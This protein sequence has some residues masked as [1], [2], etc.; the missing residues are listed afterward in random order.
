MANFRIAK[1]NIHRD[2]L[3]LEEET[4]RRYKNPALTIIN[5]SARQIAMYGGLLGLDPCS[6]QKIQGNTEDITNPFENL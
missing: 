4:G 5:E 6:R 1:K 3:I 2:G